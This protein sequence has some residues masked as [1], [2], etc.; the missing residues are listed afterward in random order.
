M[1]NNFHMQPHVRHPADPNWATDFQQLRVSDHPL[2]VEQFR[3]HAPLVKSAQGG[4]QNEFMRQQ[5]NG[6]IAMSKGKQVAFEQQQNVPAYAPQNYYPTASMPMSYHPQSL[7]MQQM[8][9]D[10]QMQLNEQVNEA[11]WSQAF[12]EAFQDAFKEAEQ[13]EQ[14]EVTNKPQIPLEDVL[15]VADRSADD[16]P[17][18]QVRI[19]S[20]AIQYTEKKDQTA[21]H[22][23]Q[24]ANALARVAGELLHNVQHDNSQKFQ[25]SQFLNLMRKIRDRQVEVRNN[26]FEATNADSGEAVA[27]LQNVSGGGEHEIRTAPDPVQDQDAFAFPNLNAVYAPREADF[28]DASFDSDQWPSE[29]RTQI[30]DL[31]PGGKLYPSLYTPTAGAQMSGAVPARPISA[32]DFDSSYDENRDFATRFQRTAA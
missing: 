14:V 18:E 32:A 17:L 5:Q 9:T 2:P 21:E 12:E 6:S 29:P 23:A 30:S 3:A 16:Q 20:D 10:A 28:V 24:D 11:D 22:E 15:N 26:D 13:V 8:P 1:G 4:W 25:N 27:S 31:H 7:D 19:G